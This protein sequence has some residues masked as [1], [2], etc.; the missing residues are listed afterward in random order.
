M[1]VLIITLIS[2]FSILQMDA[3]VFKLKLQQNVCRMAECYHPQYGF[4]VKGNPKSIK[5]DNDR[6]TLDFDKEFFTWYGKNTRTYKMYDVKRSG[7]EYS[8]KTEYQS[9]RLIKNSDKAALEIIFLYDNKWT[10]V[11]YFCLII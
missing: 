6:F 1:K 10:Y 5:A 3:Q 4:K 9:I 11:S 8:F 2:L 7:T